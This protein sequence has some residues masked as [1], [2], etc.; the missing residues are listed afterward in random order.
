M[1]SN[2]K[3]G[4]KRTNNDLNSS[5]IMLVSIIF[6]L[7]TNSVIQK[8]YAVGNIYASLPQPQSPFSS[9]STSPDDS[10]PLPSP[11][12]IQSPLESN[13]ASCDEGQAEGCAITTSLASDIDFLSACGNMTTDDLKTKTKEKSKDFTTSEVKN[14]TKGSVKFIFI[15]SYWTDNTILG[16][17]DAGSASGQSDGQSLAPVMRVESGP[18]EG[19]SVLAIK[20]VN[21]GT[22]SL[23][24]ITGELDLPSGF[25]SVVSPRNKDTSVA[26]S[27]FPTTNGG[28]VDAGQTFILYFPVKILQ[29]AK[30]GKEY[31]AQLTVH[32]FKDTDKRRSNLEVEKTAKESSHL[33]LTNQCS[34][35]DGNTNKTKTNTDRNIDAKTVHTRFDSKSQTINVPFE[36]SGKVILDVIGS[37]QLQITTE[38]VSP[39]PN[40]IN[41]LSAIPG[42]GNRLKLVIN[43]D[44]SA[45]AT[46]VIATVSAR[47]EAATNNN[48]ITPALAGNIS[49]NVV[50]QSSVIPVI[51]LGGTTFNLGTVPVSQGREIDTVVFPNNLAAGTLENLNVQL[52][53]NDAYGNKKVTNQVVGIQILPSSPQSELTVTPVPSS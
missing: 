4:N 19:E 2:N 23:T 27:S 46:G 29:N 31:N 8:P 30:V 33:E 51:I 3:I 41:V 20:L 42:V 28:A 38:N 17:V 25:Q 37:S 12:F 32:Y 48:I 22:V 36:L 50:Q 6:L 1:F 24:S 5:L 34:D 44:G 53:Y 15:N 14:I 35:N 43:N 26:L 40:T 52:T 11:S 47:I 16:G 10:F 7:L 13:Q 49:R 21:R 9:S 45:A 18:G 39:S